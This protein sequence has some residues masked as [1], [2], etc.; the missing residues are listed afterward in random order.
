MWALGVGQSQNLGHKKLA[1]LL[2]KKGLPAAIISTSPRAWAFAILGLNSF[3]AQNPEDTEAQNALF[4]L[5]EKLITLWTAFATD[6]WPWFEPSATY[7]NAR[8]C[9]ALIIG[10][11]WY[12][13][14]QATQI[15]LQTLDWLSTIQKSP[16]GYF[17]PIACHGFYEKNSSK[18]NFDQQPVEAQG[19]VAACLEALKTTQNLRWSRD[20]KMAFE[21]FLGRNEL[22]LSLYDPSTGGCKDGLQHN[23]LN[24][25]QG[26]ESSLAFHLA[27][28]EMNTLTP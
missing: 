9:Q 23:R 1:K 26:A 19:M 8:L 15:G 11:R 4:V 20:A 3:L 28:L 17:S 7:E 2:F 18:A 22:G 25:N 14:T 13:D 5:T 16:D 24:E 21:W 10:G 12:P 6:D 27:R